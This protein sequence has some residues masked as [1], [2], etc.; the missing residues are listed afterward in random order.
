MKMS[1]SIIACAS[2]IA[3]AS[4]GVAEGLIVVVNFNDGTLDK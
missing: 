3:I 1:K 4:F 2:A